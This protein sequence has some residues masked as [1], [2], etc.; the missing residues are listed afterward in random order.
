MS[1]P[2]EQAGSRQDGP[3]SF[4]NQQQ[5]HRPSYQQPQS[6]SQQQRFY[7]ARGAENADS[8][9][10]LVPG[11]APRPYQ[12]DAWAGVG[13]G[14]GGSRAHHPYGD[15]SSG[16]Y[17]QRHHGDQSTPVLAAESVP[18]VDEKWGQQEGHVSD[19]NSASGTAR[20]SSRIYADPD[21]GWKHKHD[22]GEFTYGAAK[23]GRNKKKF[24]VL[25]AILISV[26]VVVGA[27]VGVLVYMLHK[28][29]ASSSGK[30]AS[31]SDNSVDLSDPSKFEK[32]DRLH[33]S[34]YGMCYTPCKC[35]F[36][37]EC[38]CMCASFS[39]PLFSPRISFPNP[40]RQS[41]RN[42]STAVV[43]T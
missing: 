23:D 39:E 26:L 13:A 19:S 11:S 4:A 25:L 2:F 27:V 28:R 20:P 36:V 31:G 1:L 41:I 12:D 24:W 35:M 40:L 38:V 8:Q 5:A 15:P 7:G 21:A 30:G 10:A 22:S 33:Q 16:S 18:Y 32:D 37:Y 14:F 17:P 42:T 9:Q 43:R 3:Y 6:K 29:S 34:F